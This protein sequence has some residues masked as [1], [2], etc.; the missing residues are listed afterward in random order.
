VK[1]H[2]GTIPENHP[3]YRFADIRAALG[4]V[5]AFEVI[6]GQKVI[7]DLALSSPSVDPADDH[8]AGN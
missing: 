4:S 5:V 8:V 2:Q 3:D 1:L 6:S 7:V